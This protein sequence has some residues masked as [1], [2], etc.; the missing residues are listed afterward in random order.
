MTTD[1]TDLYIIA[2]PDIVSVTPSGSSRCV[3]RL[4]GPAHLAYRSGQLYIAEP[5][6]GRITA[7]NIQ[8]HQPA[9]FDSSAGYVDAMAA[10]DRALYWLDRTTHTVRSQSL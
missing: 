1:S 4:S 6:F 5:S 2:G 7:F 8:T 10:T 9:C 3:L